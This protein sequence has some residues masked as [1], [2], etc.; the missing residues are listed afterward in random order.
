MHARS[1]QGGHD[2]GAQA[3]RSRSRDP[4]PLQAVR[5]QRGRDGPRRQDDLRY[6]EHREAH[7][8]ALRSHDQEGRGGRGRVRRLC[9]GEQHAHGAREYAPQGGVFV[10]RPDQGGSRSAQ[11]G[12][13]RNPVHQGPQRSRAVSGRRVKKY[14]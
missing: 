14:K 7:R 8:G 6:G 12:V 1:Q 10:G 5:R 11:E 13:Q 4:G 2:R 9:G 3:R